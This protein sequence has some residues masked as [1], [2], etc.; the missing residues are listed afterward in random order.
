MDNS[1]PSL[2]SFLGLDVLAMDGSHINRIQ[3]FDLQMIRTMF[4]YYT[5]QKQNWD[6]VWKEV[7]YVEA[8]L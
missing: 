3:T 7:F 1:T 5:N 6:T 2:D 8:N 4:F